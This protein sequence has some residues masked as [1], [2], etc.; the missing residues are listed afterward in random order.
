MAD[1]KAPKATWA[2]T[3][4]G[5]DITDRMNPRLISLSLTEKRAGEADDLEIVLD[6]RDGK[7]AIPKKGVVLKVSIGWAQGTGLPL[8]LVDKG[9]FKVDE[10]C[11]SGPPDIITIRARS[12][13]FTSVFRVRR[14]RAYIG[15][16]VKHILTAI[17]VANGLKP[18]ID[19][20]LGEKVIPALGSGSKSDAALVRELGHRFDA[21]A[22]VKAGTLIFAPIGNGVTAGGKPIE[23]ISVDRK[24]VKDGHF[25]FQTADRDTYDGVE[26][27]W[28]D[29]AT[30][31]HVSIVVGGAGDHHPKRLRKI[32]ATE[33]DARQ[34]AEGELNRMNRAGEKLS[35][36][37]ALGR[38]DFYPDR[39]VT[40]TGF[41][42]E[43]N[44]GKWLTTEVTH[45][46]DGQGGLIGRL[47]LETASN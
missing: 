18:S 24:D 42:A 44:A 26:A 19:A 27:V 8:G 37:M 10:V 2:V 41:K 31:R 47:Q 22:T 16:T 43:I 6:D 5:T 25:D 40:V 12:A 14:E 39:A 21:V 17:A 46:M 38:P 13:D 20:T 1:T 15:K 7:L 45:A 28:H 23:A 4:D 11:A 32:Y 36:D 9:E 33:T 3:L 30:G 34:A 29:R 35:F